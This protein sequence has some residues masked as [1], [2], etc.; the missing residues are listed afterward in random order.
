MFVE[1]PDAE[2][3]K[4]ILK[5]AAKSVPLS[6]EVKPTSWRPTSTVTVRRIALPCCARPR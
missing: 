2:A 3:R 1:P 4:E 6:K 5:T